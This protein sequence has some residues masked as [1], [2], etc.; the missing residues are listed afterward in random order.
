MQVLLTVVILLPAYENREGWE[1]IK[2]WRTLDK[3]RAALY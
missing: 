2:V 3:G 1:L